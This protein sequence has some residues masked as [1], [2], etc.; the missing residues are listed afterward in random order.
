MRLSD[1]EMQVLTLIW[2]GYQIKEIGERLQLTPK[3]IKN[4]RRN[5]GLKFGV[6]TTVQLCRK[7]LEQKILVIEEVA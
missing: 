5:L 7:A 1:R 2:D 4:V 6:H 3:W